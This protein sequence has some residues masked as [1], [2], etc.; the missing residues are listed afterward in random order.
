ML[1]SSRE[2]CMVLVSAV[3]V[4]Y[5]IWKI[6]HSNIKYDRRFIMLYYANVQSMNLA[7]W[8]NLD[9]AFQIAQV[10]KVFS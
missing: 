3:L 2:W 4:S 6:A 9:K 1:G 5:V 8:K 7:Q 10:I